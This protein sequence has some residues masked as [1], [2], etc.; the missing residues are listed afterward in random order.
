MFQAEGRGCAEGQKWEKAWYDERTKGGTCGWTWRRKE[1]VVECEAAI[2]GRAQSMLGLMKDSGCSPKS[3]G[4]GRNDV[5]KIAFGEV[6]SPDI[7]KGDQ[8]GARWEAGR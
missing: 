3:N 1:I 4:K 8:K 5:I 7:S 6:I 2:K